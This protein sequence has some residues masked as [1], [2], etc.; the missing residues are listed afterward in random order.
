MNVN[1]V[2]SNNSTL[3]ERVVRNHY[4]INMLINQLSSYVQTLYADHGYR[5]IL[6]INFVN[7]TDIKFDADAVNILSLTMPANHLIDNI[8]LYD[9][10]LI[11]N[12]GESLCTS[13]LSTLKLLQRPNVYLVANS[14]LEDTHPWK[15]K[16]LF[17]ADDLPKCRN[18]FTNPQYPQYY[19][20]YTHFTGR[21]EGILLI[22]GV[23]RS[24]RNYIIE[25]IQHAIP[26]VKLVSNFSSSIAGTDESF[27][28]SKED[29]HFRNVVNNLYPILHE[30]SGEYHNNHIMINN[31]DAVALGYFFIPEYYEHSCVLFPETSW[32][33]GELCLTEKAL[34]CFYSNTFP[35]PIGGA[36]INYLY[37]QIGYYTAWNLL[38]ADLAEYDNILDHRERYALLTHAVKW[39]SD[40]PKVFES[41]RAIDWLN[42]NKLNFLTHDSSTKH[43]LQFLYNKITKRK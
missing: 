7:E 10:I 15:N 33:N 27:F 38:P 4:V 35:M 23:N 39:L 13:T 16:V 36:R 8:D 28:E 31:G 37:N 20:Q 17:F 21:R 43:T 42:K 34:K 6:N 24:W 32:L 14:I 40:N 2:A 22:N 3:P 26:T 18:Y 12:G 41:T 29:T 11:D 30:E 9:I 25:M 5:Q 1:V 19:E